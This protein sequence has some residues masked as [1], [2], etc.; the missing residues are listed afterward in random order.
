MNSVNQAYT[1]V[2]QLIVGIQRYRRRTPLTGQVT[3]GQTHMIP[4]SAKE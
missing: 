2:G 1:K 3:T 4:W